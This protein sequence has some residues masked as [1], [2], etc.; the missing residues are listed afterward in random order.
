MSGN[1][2]AAFTKPGAFLRNGETPQVRGVRWA[3]YDDEDAVLKVKFDDGKIEKFSVDS[4]TQ[5]QRTDRI[6]FVSDGTRYELRTLRD[7]DG[8]WASGVRTAVPVSSLEKIIRGDSPVEESLT[9]Y[10]LDDS[11]YVVALVY[12]GG[13]GKYSRLNGD[14]AQLDP[15]DQTLVGDNIYPIEIDRGKSDEYVRLYDKNFVS[16]TDTE[17]YESADSEEIE[18]EEQSDEAE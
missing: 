2:R 17:K 6:V 11:P 3:T 14:W 8:L 10:A 15:N 9:A 13:T 4:I 12:S 7:S 1:E 18:P 5:D 16:V